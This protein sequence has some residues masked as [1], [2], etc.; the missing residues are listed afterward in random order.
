[1]DAAPDPCTR[2]GKAFGEGESADHHGWC[3]SCRSHVVA[4]SGRIALVPALLLGV[5]LFWVLIELDLLASRW[6]IGL[7]ALVV[8]FAWLTF[9]VGRRVAFEVLSARVRRRGKR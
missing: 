6:V 5:G 2:C 9:K 4:M 7:L 8:L 3:G 1:M